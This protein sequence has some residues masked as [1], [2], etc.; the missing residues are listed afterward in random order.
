MADS[1]IVDLTSEAEWSDFDMPGGSAPVRL[2]RLRVDEVTKAP[3][4]LVHFPAGWHRDATG[5]YAD[6][7][8]FTVLEGTLRMSG[9]AY[10]GPHW[11]YAPGGYRREA[12]HMDG[13]VLAVARFDGR[14][15]WVDDETPNDIET[16]SRD[17]SDVEPEGKAPLNNGGGVLLREGEHD[18]TWW[19]TAAPDHAF[20]VTLEILDPKARVWAWI[21][22]GNQPPALGACVCRIIEEA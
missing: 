1:I 18:Q 14:A 12:T 15:R 6:A 19:L 7:E 13:D 3:T 10:A 2:A 16:L 11:V 5:H 20:G 9:R 22:A 8:E 21:P 17:L 4:S